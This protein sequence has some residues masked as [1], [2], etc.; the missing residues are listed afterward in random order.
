M[1]LAIKEGIVTKDEWF[2]LH[3]MK[4]R[5]TTDTIGNTSDKLDATGLSN[6]QVLKIYDKSNPRVNVPG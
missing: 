1:E 3:D 5:G 6:K 4:R 2:G